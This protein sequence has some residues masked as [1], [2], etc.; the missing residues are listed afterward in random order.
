[1]SNSRQQHVLD[2]VLHL[3]EEVLDKVS[4]TSWKRCW[5]CLTPPEIGVGTGVLT[6]VLT[7]D[8]PPCTD[9]VKRLGAILDDKP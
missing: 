5:I 9:V 1:M 3:L 8:H 6:P 4:N 7:L 2:S